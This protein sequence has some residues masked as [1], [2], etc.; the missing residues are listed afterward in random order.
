[1]LNVKKSNTWTM[2]E[3][4]KKK[5]DIMRFTDIDISFD[6]TYNGDQKPSKCTWEVFLTNFG[7][8]HL[9][10]QTWDGIPPRP[11]MGYIPSIASTCYVEGSMP[12]AFMQEDF[13]VCNVLVTPSYEQSDSS[14]H[15]S[16]CGSG[17]LVGWLVRCSV[18]C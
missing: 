4:H 5:I 7:D 13:L 9:L 2:E 15:H 10:P 16:V 11:G 18:V 17:C 14:S 3:V 8:L 12:L 6:I 1:M